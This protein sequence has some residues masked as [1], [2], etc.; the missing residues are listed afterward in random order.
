MESS[1]STLY[2][3]FLFCTLPVL[4]TLGIALRRPAFLALAGAWIGFLALSSW[5]AR[6]GLDGIRV[7][8]EV[9]PSAF[10][11]DEVAV[12]LLFESARPVRRI[13]IADSF[14]AAIVTEQRMLEPGP[15]GP[16]VRRRLG[17]TTICSR[18]WGIYTV[19]PVTVSRSDP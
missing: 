19:G 7:S 2:R 4:L 5:W 11:N 16:G 18:Q 9:Y 13:E 14:G 3:T 6:R 15:V 8:R 12:T 10:E 1:R 17:Y